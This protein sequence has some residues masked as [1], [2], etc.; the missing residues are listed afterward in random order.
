MSAETRTCRNCKLEQPLAK[1]RQNRN[2]CIR[3]DGL[4]NTAR[5]KKKSNFYKSIGMTTTLVTS[6]RQGFLLLEH[7]DKGKNVAVL[8]NWAIEV[9]FFFLNHSTAG[10]LYPSRKIAREAGRGR[11]KGPFKRCECRECGKEFDLVIPARILPQS[12]LAELTYR[13]ELCKDCRTREIRKN[14]EMMMENDRRALQEKS[15]E[16]IERFRDQLEN[17]QKYG[18]CDILAAHHDALIDDPERL[19]TDFLIGMVC[20]DKKR[21]RY[22]IALAKRDIDVGRVT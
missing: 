18:T 10:R 8:S 13:S 15:V 17:C 20:G 12:G 22:H 21:E 6:V 4:I 3:C 16:L 2:V 5:E 11:K 9:A 14:N 7:P 19:T 1:F